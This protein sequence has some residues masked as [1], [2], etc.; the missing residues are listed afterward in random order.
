L[1]GSAASIFRIQDNTILHS[2][3]DK[4]ISIKKYN[5]MEATDRYVNRCLGLD[6]SLSTCL[7]WIYMMPIQL[8]MKRLESKEKTLPEGRGTIV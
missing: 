6:L 8:Y 3:D 5:K 7:D 2:P 1:E 4:Q